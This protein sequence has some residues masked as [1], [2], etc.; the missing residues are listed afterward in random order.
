MHERHLRWR[1][2]LLATTSAL[3]LGLF[4]APVT[5][6]PWSGT[7]MLNVAQADS[8]DGDGDGEAGDEGGGESGDDGESDT[9]GETGG[10]SGN[11]GR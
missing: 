8:H 10:E 3:C 6:D 7:F 11:E 1:G 2:L 5:V 9:G 4:A